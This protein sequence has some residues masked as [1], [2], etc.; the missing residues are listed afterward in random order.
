MK[1]IFRRL[2]WLA[3]GS[4]LI[5]SLIS[6]SGVVMMGCQE[7]RRIQL[8]P[9]EL[10]EGNSDTGGLLLSE[11]AFSEGRSGDTALRRLTSEQVAR[12]LHD[13]LGAN[14][15]IPEV[16]EPAVAQGGLI[17]IG[18]SIASLSSRGVG[19]IETLAYTVA[20]QALDA[21]HRMELVKCSPQSARDDECATQF[22][23]QIGLR[24]WRRPLERDEV[25]EL[26]ELAGRSSEVLEDFY[27]GLEFALARLIQ[28]PQFMFRVEIGVEDSSAQGGRRFT[29][30]ELASRLSYLLWNSCPDEVL[31]KAAADG[32]LS[33]REGLLEQAERL[34]EDPRAREGLSFFFADY[35]NLWKL[36]KVRK[37]SES[38]ENYSGALPQDAR[39]ETL[40]LLEYLTFDEQADLRDMMTSRASFI[41]PLLA[42]IYRVPAPDPDGFAYVE[43]PEESQRAGVLTQVA[44]LSMHAHAIHSSATLRG[45]AVRTVLLCQDIPVPPVSVDTSIPEPSA[46]QQTLRERVAQHLT[47]PSCAGCHKLTDPIGLG[48]EN[49]DA[50]GSWR[51]LDHGAVID[52]SGELDGVEFAR[53]RELALA[54]A[55][56]PNF[57]PCFTQKLA[58][59][60]LGRP[61]SQGEEAW[62]DT[63][64]TRLEHHGYR[65]LPMIKELIASP[66]FRYAGQAQ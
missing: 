45:K 60:A 16:A 39:R 3:L 44:F 14:L 63:L 12:S 11:Q 19:S 22:V 17:A 27:S 8:D 57:S 64:T 7:A 54:I 26:V 29:D 52:P 41:N 46:E 4:T 34:L 32:L 31:L 37:D 55:T 56:H 35:L 6:L 53:P 62:L 50:L 21:E 5:G 66:L 1:H 43:F 65:L 24:L 23:E 38:F 36:A 51:T 61:L 9:A 15:L 33:T 30:Y 42:T 48:L 13:V 18:A 59:Y 28:S 25:D 49:F 58:S 47:D 2:W 10:S 20:E 40:R